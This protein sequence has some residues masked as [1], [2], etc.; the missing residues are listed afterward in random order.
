MKL[1]GRCIVQKSRPSS[2]LGAKAP[3]VAQPQNCSFQLRRWKNQ[4][5]LSS[6]GWFYFSHIFTIEISQ[7]KSASVQN[8]RLHYVRDLLMQWGSR[9]HVHMARA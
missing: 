4:R 6:C 2:N 9:V 8:F 5:R 7:P 3:L 1:G